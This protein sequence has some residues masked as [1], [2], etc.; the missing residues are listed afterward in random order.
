MRNKPFGER[1]HYSQLLFKNELNRL[2]N[3]S[4]FKEAIMDFRQALTLQPSSDQA[5][6]YLDST[7]AQ[8]E[9]MRLNVSSVA[10]VYVNV[11]RYF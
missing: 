1:K 10:S 2:A 11:R 3:M 4:K 9:H 7:I 8:E 6:R 5:Q